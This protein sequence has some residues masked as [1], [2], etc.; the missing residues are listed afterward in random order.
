[1]SVHDPEQ[2]RLALRRRPVLR[3]SCVRNLCQFIR[4][5]AC[6]VP[7]GESLCAILEGCCAHNASQHCSVL[8]RSCAGAL[9]ELCVALKQAPLPRLPQLALLHALLLGAEAPDEARLQKRRHL[10]VAQCSQPSGN[11][12][13][14][15]SPHFA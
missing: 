15:A 2:L 14:F 13:L 3:T 7:V 11:M 12:V 6:R 8:L 5:R 1:M 4:E 10:A 9:P